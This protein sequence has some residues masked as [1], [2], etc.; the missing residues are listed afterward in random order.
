M[1]IAFKTESLEYRLLISTGTHARGK[2]GNNT[3]SFE[4]RLHIKIDKRQ[5][6]KG[7]IGNRSLITGFSKYLSKINYTF[8]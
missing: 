1:V 7:G 2:R 4:Y 6:A 8:R 5:E 3:K